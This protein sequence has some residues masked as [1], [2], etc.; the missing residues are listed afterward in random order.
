MV[1]PSLETP[2]TAL[3][4]G[5]EVRLALRRRTEIGLL[6]VRPEGPFAKGHPL[7]AASFPLGRLEA[8]VADRLPRRSVPLVVYGEGAEDAAAAAAR[9]ASLGY[10]DVSLLEGG[11]AGWAAGGGE[12]FRDVNAPSKAFGELVEA[13]A[14]TPAMP[15]G[16]LLALLRSGADVVVLDARR[17][18]EYHTMS[19][20]TATS[21]P[22]AELAMR[23]GALAPDPA[24]LVVVNCA[25]RTRSIIGTQSLI[26][27]GLPNRVVAL[28]NGTIGWNLAGLELEHGQER[29]APEVPPAM[30]RRAEAAAWAVARKA[31]A[32][33]I[34]AT[35]LAS[36]LDRGTRTVYRFDVRSPED[37]AAGH[38][39]GFRSAPGGQL[40]QETDR[41]AP[42]RGALVVLAG[43]GGGRAAM[44]AS[45]LAQMGW[46]VAVL[47][48]A[49][50]GLGAGAGGLESSDGLGAGGDGL[51]FE[52]GPW[53]PAWPPPP[54][55]P[56]ADPAQVESWLRDG[57]TA[58]IDVDSSRLFESGHVPGAAWALRTDLG[59]P[60]L[61]DRLGRP[62]R[63]VLTSADGMLARFAAADLPAGTQV[64]VL[65]GGT[66][67]WARSGRPLECG[68]AAMLSPVIDV[69]RRPYEGTGVHPD[70]MQAYLDWEYGLVGQLERDGTHGFRVLR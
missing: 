6:D 23:A 45:W 37:Y 70:A 18:E 52:T 61:A 32:G 38:L 7:F 26:N 47:G 65:A 22:G 1:R 25:G 33:R 51:A 24:T 28:R 43:D 64:L 21:V 10:P 62:D 17:F 50:D 11:L 49:T 36:L 31:G 2:V 29:R 54:G 14:G 55:P 59:E 20:P 69:Y 44:T 63:L 5:P 42:V 34:G 8:E 15:A 58:V 56:Q 16:Q 4:S 46:E 67:G 53:A 41:F 35:A 68:R 57:G 19:I 13:T 66:T 40:V 39:A 27:A 60:G 30:A 12:L 3:T 9:L 48:V